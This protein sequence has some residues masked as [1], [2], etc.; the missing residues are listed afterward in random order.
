MTILISVLII[1]AGFFENVH[2]AMVQVWRIY[3]ICSFGLRWSDIDFGCQ[4]PTTERKRDSRYIQS[5]YVDEKLLGML[6]TKSLF[7]LEI[8]LFA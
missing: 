7:T 4:V 8:A 2:C 6:T 3:G 1:S 5:W